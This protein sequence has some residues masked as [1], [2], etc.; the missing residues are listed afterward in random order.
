MMLEMATH[1]WKLTCI[2]HNRTCILFFLNYRMARRMIS[3]YNIRL[4]LWAR[5]VVDS[6]TRN[7]V[8]ASVAVA[9][10]LNTTGVALFILHGSTAQETLIAAHLVQAGAAVLLALGL[11]FLGVVALLRFF[12]DHPKAAHCRV[13]TI[14]FFT[15]AGVL[16]MSSHL[17]RTATTFF[18][19]KPLDPASA[20]VLSKIVYYSTGFGIEVLIVALYTVMKV[21]LLFSRR[22]WRTW[23]PQPKIFDFPGVGGGESKELELS[24]DGK[25]ADVEE[26]RYGAWASVTHDDKH[27]E[28]VESVAEKS[29]SKDGEEILVPHHQQKQSESE[30]HS[31]AMAIKIHTT[32]SV[33][34]TS[35]RP[36]SGDHKHN[37]SE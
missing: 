16:T 23:A 24:S 32:F 36:T 33:S 29:S 30:A 1:V 35:C 11:S 20:V 13:K 27:G 22:L 12:A 14:V 9:F 5:T 6:T 37:D 7:S 21:D 26:S 31:G 2:Y 34:S 17:V 19:W 18:V 3:F 10:A 28:V 25:E 15:G 8:L 4:S